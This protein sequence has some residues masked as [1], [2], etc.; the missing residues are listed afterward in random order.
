MK[1]VLFV[2]FLISSSLVISLPVAS[3]DIILTPKLGS[4]V[5]YGLRSF[6]GV[7]L[8]A[9]SVS[10][11]AKWCPI[12]I[13]NV[14]SNGFSISATIY[15]YEYSSSPFSQQVYYMRVKRILIN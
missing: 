9:S 1:K 7:E 10:V 4:S 6:A 13:N 11:T 8:Q 3:Q 15:L 2:L 5:L 12:V 14:Y